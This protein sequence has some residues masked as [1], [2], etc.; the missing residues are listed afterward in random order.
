MK[1]T[2]KIAALFTLLVN[3]NSFDIFAN[4]KTDMK[5]IGDKIDDAAHDVKEKFKDTAHKA[6]EKIQE[7]EKD[8]KDKFKEEDSMKKTKVRFIVENEINKSIERSGVINDTSSF[9]LKMIIPDGWKIYS[10]EKQSIGKSLFL[11]TIPLDVE[12]KKHDAMDKQKPKLEVVFPESTIEYPDPH[13][14]SK[15]NH[16]Y[17]GTIILKIKTSYYN[18]KTK[19]LLIDYTMCGEEGKCINY[20]NEEVAFDLNDDHKIEDGGTIETG[21]NKNR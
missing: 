5:D 7:A 6:K 21:I 12:L 15:V 19:K 20:T 4:V 2:L 9:D 3:I 18:Q 1:K 11:K 17:K 16:I 13:D 8:I 10:H 14:K